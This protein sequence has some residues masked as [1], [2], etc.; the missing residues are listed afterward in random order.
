MIINQLVRVKTIAFADLC[1]GNNAAL[2]EKPEHLV[3]V[4]TRN[5]EQVRKKKD[6]YMQLISH[7]AQKTHYAGKQDLLQD[8]VALFLTFCGARSTGELF[9]FLHCLWIDC[10]LL[11]THI[12]LLQLKLCTDVL[13][14]NSCWHRL[15]NVPLFLPQIRTVKYSCVRRISQVYWYSISTNKLSIYTC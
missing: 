6:I 4:F 5:P 11:P 2:Q 13:M 9:F 14:L 15:V 8:V 3:W 7:R 10:Y 1:V 12:V